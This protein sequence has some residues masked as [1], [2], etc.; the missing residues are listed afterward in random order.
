MLHNMVTEDEL[1]CQLA[2]NFLNSSL[3]KVTPLFA[4]SYHGIDMAL[5]FVVSPGNVS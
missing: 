3:S 1:I 4:F 5:I 2:G